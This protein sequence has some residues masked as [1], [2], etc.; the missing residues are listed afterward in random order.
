MRKI[1]EVQANDSKEF[2]D[3][4]RGKTL[5]AGNVT[6]VNAPTKT[7]TDADA[8]F[9]AAGVFAGC[10]LIDLT[11]DRAA[12]VDSVAAT[13]LVL[14]EWIPILATH[15]YIV[16]TPPVLPQ[17][18][19]SIDFR[20]G[21]PV[22][23]LS[24]DDAVVRE[25]RVLRRVYTWLMATGGVDANRSA[26]FYVPPGVDNVTIELPFTHNAN[27]A[28]HRY[29]GDW[30]SLKEGDAAIL[31]SGTGLWAAWPASVP[32]ALANNPVAAGSYPLHS[33]VGAG[34]TLTYLD[35][36]PGWYR[37]V[38]TAAGLDKTFAVAYAI[39]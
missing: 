27:I 33:L 34:G 25:V 23:H 16:I 10:Y 11:I 39:P 35:I 3:I 14:D 36:Q 31:P 8:G 32:H 28:V 29:H 30:L 24:Q 19:L 5:A 20:T 17:H 13:N 2:K 37:L 22:M 18:L 15:R 38:S 9:V 26:A 21:M 7:V 6:G 1:R 4:I 12:K